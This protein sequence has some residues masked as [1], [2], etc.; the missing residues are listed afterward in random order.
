M[1]PRFVFSVEAR[2]LFAYNRPFDLQFFG[3][4]DTFVFING[5]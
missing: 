2:Y 3:D 4:D 5:V 1:V